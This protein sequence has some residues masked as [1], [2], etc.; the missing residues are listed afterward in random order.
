MKDEEK[1]RKK[2]RKAEG[3]EDQH[4]NKEEYYIF[5]RQGGGEGRLL[6]GKNYIKNKKTN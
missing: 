4:G 3:K 1:G 5:I 2:G 6:K